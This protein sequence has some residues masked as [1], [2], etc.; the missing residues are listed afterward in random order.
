MH[1]KNSTNNIIPEDFIVI[2]NKHVFQFL[3]NVHSYT[4]EVPTAKI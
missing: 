4:N 3:M 1:S 2:C